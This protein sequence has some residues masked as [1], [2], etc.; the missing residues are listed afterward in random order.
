MLW[1]SPSVQQK[2]HYVSA[3]CSAGK[4]FQDGKEDEG[5]NENYLSGMQGNDGNHPDENTETTGRDGQMFHLIR[6]GE[7]VM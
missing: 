6:Q 7:S 4:S 2:T 1:L 3:D 5:T